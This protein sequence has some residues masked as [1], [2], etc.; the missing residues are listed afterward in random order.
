MQ[1]H[2][3]LGCAQRTSKYIMTS[4]P[5]HRCVVTRGM[6]KDVQSKGCSAS[7]TDNPRLWQESFYVSLRS[8]RTQ[9]THPQR[10]FKKSHT[11]LRMHQP[12][13]TRAPCLCKAGDHLSKARPLSST[14]SS[15]T[16][17]SH[18]SQFQVA[19]WK[20]RFRSSRHLNARGTSACI[21]Q[22]IASH[23]CRMCYQGQALMIYSPHARRK[24]NCSARTYTACG[25]ACS[26][27]KEMAAATD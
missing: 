9:C 11:T 8:S 4:I 19:G 23:S 24:K 17:P 25:C 3:V 5:C 14:T 10:C 27:K 15:R 18:L 16:R 6:S 26:P 1:K 13:C 12:A 2:A 20:P 22:S 21:Y 7:L